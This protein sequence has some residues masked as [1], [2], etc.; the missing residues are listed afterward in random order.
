MSDP[1]RH[2]EVIYCDDIREE[3]GGKISL[4]GIYT[5]DMIVSSM[6]LLLPKLCITVNAVT[7]IGDPLQTLCINIYKEGVTEPIISTG[8]IPI[9]DTPHDNNSVWQAVNMVFALTPFQ[10]DEET[11]LRVAADTENGQ[12]IGRSL[13]IIRASA[14]EVVH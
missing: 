13:R 5:G 14:A 12:I 10:I 1:A 11:R 4:M 9:P 2:L 7:P 8:V 6:P 3:V